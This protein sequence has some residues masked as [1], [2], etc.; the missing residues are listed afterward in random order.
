MEIKGDSVPLDTTMS[1]SSA[2]DRDPLLSRNSDAGFG[3]FFVV[4]NF[5][6]LRF[7]C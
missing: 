2:D 6:L 7:V 4:V 3:T 5:V 1:S